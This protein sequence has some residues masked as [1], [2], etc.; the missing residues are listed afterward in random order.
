M[1]FRG[2]PNHINLEGGAQAKTR[3]FVVKI[4][5]KVSTNALFCLFFFFKN[6]TAAQK[7]WSKW[8]L[9]SDLREL[10]KSIWP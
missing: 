9:Y 2:A 6:L 7:N 1:F 3:N 10:R 4:F 8:G 5:Q